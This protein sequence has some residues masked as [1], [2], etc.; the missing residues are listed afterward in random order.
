[1]ANSRS[2]AW[3][4]LQA[5]ACFGGFRRAAAGVQGVAGGSSSMVGFGQGMAASQSKSFLSSLSPL[6]FAA[7]G[8]GGATGAPFRTSGVA[9]AS[10]PGVVG[11]AG[12]LQ[13]VQL[14]QVRYMGGKKM[15][16]WSSLK[17]RFKL[18]KDGKFTRSRCGN[19]HLA[20]SKSK[21]QKR[22]LRQ[23][24][25]THSGYASI[26]KRLGFKKSKYY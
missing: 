5:T 25:T 22:R 19:A 26:M 15:K 16:S 4:S 11:H 3:E 13:P 20:S 12:A 23:S 17:R 24:T 18:Q 6:G 9:L 21:T 2:G 1:M 14:Q 7:S 10:A 8:A